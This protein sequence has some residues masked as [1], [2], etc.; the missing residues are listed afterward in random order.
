MNITITTGQTPDDLEAGRAAAV[1]V[2]KQHGGA[3][4][5]L[6]GEVVT[7]DVL[8]SARKEEKEALRLIAEGERRLAAAK[9]KKPGDVSVSVPAGALSAETP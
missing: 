2:L 1:A 5:T 3:E 8:R 9:G 6:N 7:L 4:C